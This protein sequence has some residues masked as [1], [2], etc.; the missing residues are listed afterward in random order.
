MH[1]S[2]PVQPVTVWIRDVFTST[3]INHE[4]QCEILSYDDVS[5]CYL[6]INKLRDTHL[7]CDV[8]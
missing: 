4:I 8:K 2:F 6:L 7:T 3:K 5:V 1:K